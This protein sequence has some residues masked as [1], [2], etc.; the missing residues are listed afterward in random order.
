MAV[1]DRV[2]KRV[3]GPVALGTSNGTLGTVG[4]SKQWTTKQFIFTNTSGAEALIY[5]AIGT[6]ATASNRLFSALPIAFNDTIVFDTA[7]VLDATETIQGYAD[8]AGV[9]VTVVG[10]EKSV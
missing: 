3:I 7:L 6:S 9:N 1:G 8:R 4:A 2:E 5:L 10:W